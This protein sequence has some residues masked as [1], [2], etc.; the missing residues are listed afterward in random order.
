[1]SRPSF[2]SLLTLPL[3]AALVIAGP[4]IA[5]AQGAGTSLQSVASKILQQTTCTEYSYESQS[6]PG[7]APCVFQSTS[8]GPWTSVTDC[9]GWVSFA[10]NNMLDQSFPTV[11][12]AAGQSCGT[13]TK[14][15]QN[16][17]SGLKAPTNSTTWISGL[18]NYRLA[19]SA[20][21]SKVNW[22]RAFVFTALASDL[23]YQPTDQTRAKGAQAASAQF[24][25]V[26]DMRTVQAG[27]VVSWC[28][29]GWC[30]GIAGVGDTGHVMII[31]APPAGPGTSYQCTG[32]PALQTLTSTPPA[33]ASVIG[34]PVIDSSGSHYP[35]VNA[36]DS[37]PVYTA[38]RGF[39]G[40]QNGL[41]AGCIAV[42]ITSAGLPIAHA[43]GG[44][45]TTTLNLGT[46]IGQ[47]YS[48]TDPAQLTDYTTVLRL[49]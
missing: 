14:S 44:N 9:S 49:K 36:S 30:N 41:G 33:G 40:M 2:P 5:S 8:G 20:T 11:P 23:V 32:L 46:P 26:S 39:N 24:T 13:I 27:D 10:I 4:A 21:E 12:Q 35:L 37:S 43:M 45:W 38:G 15:L 34:I 1:M 7:E 42:A 47:V 16:Y 17:C 22:P 6:I 29:G 48:G 18:N 28:R 3:A 25:A 31:N 19:F